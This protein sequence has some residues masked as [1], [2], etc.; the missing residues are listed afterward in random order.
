MLFTREQLQDPVGLIRG[1]QLAKVSHEK[2]PA[3]QNVSRE[4]LRGFYTSGIKTARVHLGRD[5]PII[6]M[7][8]P[9]WLPWWQDNAPRSYRDDGNILFS[10]HFYKFPQPWTTDLDDAKHTFRRDF[11]N[12][13]RFSQHSGYDLLLTEWG[14]NSHG[15]GKNQVFDYNK[16]ANWF[17][18]KVGRWALG[19]F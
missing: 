11:D 18:H 4:A 9:G 16:F 19:S 1:F 15:S 5:K 6:I 14:L 12:L 13:Q 17:V 8:W 2:A 3:V 10:T 7:D